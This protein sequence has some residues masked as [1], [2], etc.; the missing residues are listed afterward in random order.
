MTKKMRQTARKS[1]SKTTVSTTTVAKPS[2]SKNHNH[3]HMKRYASSKRGVRRR[4]YDGNNDDDDDTEDNDDE[5]P[6][7]AVGKYYR[8]L[9]ELYKVFILIIL[10]FSFKS[11]F[12]MRLIS[13]KRP[14]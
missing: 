13:F 5:K 10:G 9:I 14:T 8:I 6:T 3:Q 2:K 1:T 7:V 12:V 11:E 4:A